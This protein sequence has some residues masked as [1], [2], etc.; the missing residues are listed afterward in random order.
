[1]AV[2]QGLRRDVKQ[3]SGLRECTEAQHPWKRRS[4]SQGECKG[5]AFDDHMYILMHLYESELGFL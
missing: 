4:L 2:V 3:R 1:M 5:L